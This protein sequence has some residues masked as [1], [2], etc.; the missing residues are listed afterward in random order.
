[1]KSIWDHWFA[2]HLNAPNNRRLWMDQGTQT[3]DA[4]YAPNQQEV[5]ARLVASDWHKGIDWESRVY[6]S[7]THEENSW[8]AHLS[9]ILIWLLEDRVT[10]DD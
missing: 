5:D 2:K 6:P 3:L 1:M 9:K 4:F 7:A 8:A 10:S